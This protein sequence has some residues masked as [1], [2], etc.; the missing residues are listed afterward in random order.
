MTNHNSAETRDLKKLCHMKPVGL[1]TYLDKI[2]DLHHCS[3][4]D[5]F[6]PV[7]YSSLKKY[8]LSNTSLV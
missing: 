6:L 2:I 1:V 4:L 7:M 8:F 5:S 3:E